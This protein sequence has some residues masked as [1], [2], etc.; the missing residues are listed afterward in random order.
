MV[1]EGNSH[2]SWKGPQWCR[3]GA[4]SLPLCELGSIRDSY[5][6]KILPFGIFSGVSPPKTAIKLC[7]LQ[8]S[9]KSPSARTHA[10]EVVVAQVWNVC[11]HT[12]GA[13]FCVF[14]GVSI[15]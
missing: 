3:I 5:A 12:I 15:F 13:Y 6:S 2:A 8:L 9:E 10:L 1:S 4:Q 11:P 14:C 7:V